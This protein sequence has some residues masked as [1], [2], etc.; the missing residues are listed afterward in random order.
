MQ[1]IISILVQH[2]EE[3][4]NYKSAKLYRVAHSRES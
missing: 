3:L 1:F 4:N 2:G